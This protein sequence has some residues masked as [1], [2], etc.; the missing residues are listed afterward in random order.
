MADLRKLLAV[1]PGRTSLRRIDPRGKPG[2]PRGR[3]V[4]ENP[5]K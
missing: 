5:K 3:A 1:R 4:D 2:L